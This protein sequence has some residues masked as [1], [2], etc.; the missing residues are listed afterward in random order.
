MLFVQ[1]NILLKASVNNFKVNKS[2][3]NG[4]LSCSPV[5]FFTSYI[6]QNQNCHELCIS[7]ISSP[8]DFLK[9]SSRKKS[10]R[11]SWHRA[12]MGR[13]LLL[14]TSAAMQRACSDLAAVGNEERLW[15][16]QQFS[17]GVLLM[18]SSYSR[19]SVTSNI[20]A[21][22]IPQAMPARRTGWTQTNATQQ[23]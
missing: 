2:L 23:D 13:F 8:D 15:E 21:Q 7:L 9:A 18:T 1:A 22:I 11:G 5:F 20:G 6:I 4:C 19:N 14:W 10:I 17:E 12:S 16:W 3:F